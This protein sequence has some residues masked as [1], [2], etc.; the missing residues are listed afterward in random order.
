[1]SRRS[2]LSA[3]SL[4]KLAGRHIK[5]PV[6]SKSL[7]DLQLEKNFFNLMN[8][9][10]KEGRANKIRQISIRITDLCNL[11]CVMCG[12]WGEQGFLKGCDLKELKKTE[13]APERYIQL[14]DDVYEQGHR[15]MIYLWGGEPLMYDGTEEI[16]RHAAR[17]GLPTSIATNGTQLSQFADAFTDAPMYLCQVSVDGHNAELQNA[18][19]PTASG[20]NTFANVVDGL[21]LVKDMR[22]SKKRGFPLIATLTTISASNHEHIVDIY[23]RFKDTA[24]LMVFYLSWWIDEERADAHAEDFK[25]RFGFEPKL[26]RGWIGDWKPDNI[27]AINEQLLEVKKRMAHKGNPPAILIPD[28]TGEENLTSYYTDHSN[29][30]GWDQCVSIYQYVEIDSNGDMSPCRDYHD[31]V[32]GNVKDQTIS[33]LWNSQKYVDFRKSLSNDGLMPVCS[34]CCGLM[35]F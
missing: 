5:H 23:E 22:D 21:E 31:Y 14:L 30:F 32:V 25:E 18:I 19:R 2:K 27:K 29:Y 26:H 33:Q 1:M 20:G 28:I 15:P 6:L 9:N 4:L 8:P 13:V 16:I 24:D 7:V 11:R 35:G 12:Q 3:L 10:Y 34:R 17:L